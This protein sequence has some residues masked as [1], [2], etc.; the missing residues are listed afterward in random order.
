MLFRVWNLGP[1]REA[2]IDLSKDLIVLTGPNNTGKT[3]LT[4]AV[5]GL[6]SDRMTLG[7]PDGVYRWA[8]ALFAARRDG[9]VPELTLAISVLADSVVADL[10]Y[11]LPD[12]F[13]SQAE[14]LRD[15]RAELRCSAVDFRNFKPLSVTL[16]G[17]RY[18][19]ELE[20]DKLRFTPLGE[21]K[22]PFR[23][24]DEGLRQVAAFGLRT[25]LLTYLLELDTVVFPVE[26]LAI[27]LFARE[28][29]ANRTQLVDKLLETTDEPQGLLRRHA[30][31]Y[32]RAI[33]DSLQ[34]ALTL[35]GTKLGQFAELADEL[36]QTVLGGKLSKTEFDELQFTPDASTDKKPIGLHQSASVIKSLASLVWHLRYDATPGQRL[37]ID[38]PELNLHPDNQRRVARVLAKA[39]NRGLKIMM[40]TH[41]DYLVRELNNLIMLSQ[42]SDAARGLVQ[43]MGIDPLSTIKPDRL[44]V[45][46]VND[47]ACRRVRVTETGFEV[48]TIDEEI[49]R[50][51]RDS[52][53]IYSRLFCE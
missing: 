29:A 52:Q 7:G 46:L 8:E 15:A 35:H 28:L 11:R 5:Y 45:Y 18:R 37:I 26:R 53:T 21:A 33:R 9:A 27:N 30:G 10:L 44:G 25:G 50:L 42:D 20:T 39:V 49:H 1:I 12:E 47:G 22:T 43:E 48:K 23:N 19:I 2:E 41:S 17:Y 3:Y 31:R 40:S 6:M 36:E 34:R 13:A 38:E 51:N 24:D 14:R 32:P 4:W 16:G